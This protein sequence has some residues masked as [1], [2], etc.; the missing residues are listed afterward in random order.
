MLPPGWFVSGFMPGAVALGAMAALFTQP[1]QQGVPPTQAAAS[2]TTPFGAVPPTTM[3]GYRGPQQPQGPFGTTT[4]PQGP[5]GHCAAEIGHIEAKILRLSSR[6]QH[7]CR[8][9]AQRCP[10]FLPL[11]LVGAAAAAGEALVGLGW[12]PPSWLL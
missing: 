6:L 5:F 12:V 10:E 4:P 3:G 2:P 8:I 11:L 7:L 9:K 1:P